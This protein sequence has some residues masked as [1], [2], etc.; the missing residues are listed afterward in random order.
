MFETLPEDFRKYQ[1]AL[2]KRA[3]EKSLRDA[4]LSR[5]EAARRTASTSESNI[6][7]MANELIIK[8]FQKCLTK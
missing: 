4:G 1:N 6:K 7:N 3:E 8:E 5:A 2:K